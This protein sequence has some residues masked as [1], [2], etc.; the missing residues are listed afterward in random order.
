LLI[1]S[2]FL[3]NGRYFETVA[4]PENQHVHVRLHI[5]KKDHGGWQDVCF[6]PITLVVGDRQERVIYVAE[7]PDAQFMK[8][9]FPAYKEEMAY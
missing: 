2:V 3:I 6:S 8:L 7:L 1:D 4:I 5:P 9:E